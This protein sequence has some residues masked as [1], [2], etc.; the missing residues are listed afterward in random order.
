[1]NWYLT[2][3]VRKEMRKRLIEHKWVDLVKK[4]SNPYQ[5]WTRVSGKAERALEDMV[6]L[7]RRLPN[8]KQELIFTYSRPR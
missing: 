7:T 5:T 6:L 1:M 4:E 3:F 2:Y 8:D